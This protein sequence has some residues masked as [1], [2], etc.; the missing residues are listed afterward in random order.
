MQGL[1]CPNC[2]APA[3]NKNAQGALSC[4]SCKTTFPRVGSAYL[5]YPDPGAALMDWRNR[6]NRRRAELAAEIERAENETSKLASAETRRT[7]T[8]DHLKQHLEELDV[9]LKPLQPGEAVAPEVYAAIKQQLPEHHGVDSYMTHIFR[10]WCWGDVENAK[11]ADTIFNAIGASITSTPKRVLVL[12]SGA[13][14]LA[15]DLHERLE[16]QQTIALDSN[17]PARSNRGRNV[18]GEPDY[19][20]PNLRTHQSTGITSLL[21]DVLQSEPLTNIYSVCGDAMQA[22]VNPGD[23]D[24][25][26]TPWLL[27]VLDT[28]I[29][30]SLG[31]IASYLAPDAHWLM[32]GSVAFEHR[33]VEQRWTVDDL[34]DLAGT[35]GF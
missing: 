27:D 33:S 24:L 5:L 30:Q 12:G 17:P 25:V 13:G 35:S 23:F 16:P 21:S 20:S 11:V 28:P 15:Y 6:F 4:G 31:Q 10:D 2:G 29:A 22:P 32:H 7:L 1:A 14:R 19:P 18:C 3:L 8:V 34:P 26:I 9:I